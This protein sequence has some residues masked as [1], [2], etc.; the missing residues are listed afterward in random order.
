[1]GDRRRIEE[2]IFGKSSGSASEA[3][4]ADVFVLSEVGRKKDDGDSNPFDSL[5]LR[6]EESD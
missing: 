4:D 2:R 6:S 1:M 5:R 3:S